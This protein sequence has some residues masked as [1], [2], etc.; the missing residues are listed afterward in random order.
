MLQRRVEWKKKN[1]MISIDKQKTPWFPLISSKNT[2]KTKNTWFGWSGTLS[3]VCVQQQKPCAHWL[4]LRADSHWAK[5]SVPEVKC[6]RGSPE[7]SA[8]FPLGPFFWKRAVWLVH[9]LMSD[10][11]RSKHSFQWS[12][13]DS[14]LE[15]SVPFSRQ[16]KNAL[17]MGPSLPEK[18]PSGKR[19][20]SS[21]NPRVH[22]TS[23]T[24]HLAQCESAQK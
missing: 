16:R 21:G 1:T 11:S 15:G 6:T 12:N 14:F 19:A 5:W 24:L 2:L 3:F 7:L 10:L 22:F 17:K 8:L 4:T 18:G 9:M 23:G 13:L 20:E